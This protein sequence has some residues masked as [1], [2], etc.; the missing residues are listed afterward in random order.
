MMKHDFNMLTYVESCLCSK[1]PLHTLMV[2]DE[3]K[4]SYPVVYIITF[5]NN[6]NNLSKWMDAIKGKMQQSKPNW[7]PNTFI[8]D[9]VNVEIN[10]LR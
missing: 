9:D 4:N 5:W 2:F 10:N 8:V 1:F 6:Q 7:K 3:W